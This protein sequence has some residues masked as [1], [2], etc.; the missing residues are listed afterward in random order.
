MSFMFEVYYRQPPDTQKEAALME[1]VVSLGGRMTYREV[2]DD[3][4][5]AAVCLTYEFDDRDAVEAAAKLLREQGE[6]V[7]G[8]SDYGPPGRRT[9]IERKRRLLALDK[10]IRD[11][12][13]QRQL[14]ADGR[15]PVPQPGTKIRRAAEDSAKA[16]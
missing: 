3:G 6:H 9:Q 16:K 1:R 5:T 4:I 2:P 8:P 13:A 14:D 15:Y 7:E 12:P 11:S 10:V